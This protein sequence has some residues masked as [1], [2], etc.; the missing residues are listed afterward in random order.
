MQVEEANTADVY[1]I[2]LNQKL[3]ELDGKHPLYRTDMFELLT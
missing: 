2:C 1:Q 3:K